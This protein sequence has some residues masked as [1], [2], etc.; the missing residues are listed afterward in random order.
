MRRCTAWAPLC[1][2]F[3]V[4][5]RLAGAHT[6]TLT[7]VTVTF[8]TT[9]ILDVKIGID[10]TQIL[11][12]PDR[13]YAFVTEPQA[14]QQAEVR[15]LLP[16]VLA[17]LQ[18]VIGT[19]PLHLELTQFSTATANKTLILDSQM[20]TLST[21][22]FT[23]ALPAS[24]A[25]LR[26]LVPVGAPIDYPV[27][28]TLQIPAAHV[29][30]TRWLEDGAHESEPYDWAGKA[31]AAVPSADSGF[32]YPRVVTRTD[33]GTPGF[34]PD[35]LPWTRQA[36]LYLRLGFE[37]IVPEGADH[38]LFVLGLCFL[39]LTLRK[40][41]SQTTV[42]TIAHATTL[43][44]S[45]YGIFSLP[46]SYVEPGIALSIA[47]IAIENVY[48]PRLGPSRLAV[49]F[50]FGLVHGL[51]FASSL[52]DIPFPKHDFIVALLGFN[53]G[54]DFGQLFV[55]A[56]TF[57]LVG[58]FRHKVWFRQRIAIPASLAIA[59]IGLVWAVQRVIFYSTH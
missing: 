54:V 32:D 53:F 40:L 52:S 15:T 6:M 45:T 44:L 34:D 9:G 30:M 24:H 58:W 18:L 19:T 38:I 16:Q 11:G 57:S 14:A 26:L 39:G 51:G 20:S 37:H 36:A 49:V 23:A 43:F 29:S 2:L 50:C 4:W 56:V 41:L 7:E 46:E 47:W 33:P 35:E 8:A 27:V 25:P 1:M 48:K 13:Y 22:R 31:A 28:Y 59:A 5:A 17:G 12:S 21:F 42:F 10:L 55:I 3:M